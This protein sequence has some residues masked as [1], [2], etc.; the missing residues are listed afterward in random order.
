[1]GRRVEIPEC[2]SQW[3]AGDRFGEIVGTETRMQFIRG[4]VDEATGRVEHDEVVWVTELARVKLEGSGE[5]VEVLLADCTEYDAAGHKVPAA[6]KF[7]PHGPAPRSDDWVREQYEEEITDMMVL[8]SDEILGEVGRQRGEDGC[9][10][11]ED[12]A[13]L[14][15]ICREIAPAWP[16]GTWVC[17]AL[18]GPRHL[19]ARAITRRAAVE[20]AGVTRAEWGRDGLGLN[21][22]GTCGSGTR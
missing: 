2:T 5:V 14:E 10:S 3:L 6:R 13:L 18:P 19:C 15:K 4:R 11:E 7:K 1:M 12:F 8:C 22:E 21:S 16:R 20:S 9:W 17:S